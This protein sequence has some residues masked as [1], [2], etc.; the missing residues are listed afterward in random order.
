MERKEKLAK[1][2]TLCL[3]SFHATLYFAA[4]ST[5][6]SLSRDSSTVKG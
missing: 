5:S 6:T 2:K 4:K 1:I 3:N